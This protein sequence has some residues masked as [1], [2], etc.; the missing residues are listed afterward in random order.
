MDDAGVTATVAGSRSIW[1]ASSAIGARHRRREEQRLPAR[2]NLCDDL[3]NVVDKA[4][5]EHP[6]GF[7]EHQMLHVAEP[8]RIVRDEI[9]QTPGR[10]DQQST[11]LSKERTCAPMDTPPM[12]SAA[13]TPTW[14]PYALKLSRI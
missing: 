6:V 8:Q 3:P 10:R 14:R 1:L 13:L 7:I 9:E 12:A 5:V 4:H 2:G 11:P